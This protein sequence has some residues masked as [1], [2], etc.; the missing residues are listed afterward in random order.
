[1]TLQEFLASIS[2]DAESVQ[3]AWS[4]GGEALPHFAMWDI[5]SGEIVRLEKLPMEVAYGP[6]TQ[7]IDGAARAQALVDAEAV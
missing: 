6:L 4:V 7:V 3:I 1:M 2:A 5:D